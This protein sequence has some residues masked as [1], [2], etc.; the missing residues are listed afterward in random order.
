MKIY[1][2]KFHPKRINRIP[3]K[4]IGVWV[5]SVCFFL[6][7]IIHFF[8]MYQTL[9]DLQDYKIS[10]DRVRLL[11]T[12]DTKG[13][14]NILEIVSGN[15]TYY[16]RYPSS[17]YLD[18]AHDVENDLL[19]GRVSLVTAKVANSYSLRDW[20]GNRKW[21]VDLRSG[22]AVYYDLNTEAI[23]FRREHISLGIATI[24]A[25]I[26]LLCYTIIVLLIYNV[27]ILNWRK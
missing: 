13:R 24:F 12:Y 5:F 4:A 16:L 15:T 20:L 9:D 22:S 7:G 11:D 8:L 3:P 10:I 17:K 27:L 23:S 19:S 21:V 25:F 18:F 2:M 6:Y 14:R 1:S 26:F